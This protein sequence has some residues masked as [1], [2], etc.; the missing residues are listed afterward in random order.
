MFKRSLYDY[1]GN[2]IGTFIA[3]LFSHK[4]PSHQNMWEFVD[5]VT[6]Y[7]IIYIKFLN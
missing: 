3:F 7:E 5:I 2:R 4:E 6:K 1:I